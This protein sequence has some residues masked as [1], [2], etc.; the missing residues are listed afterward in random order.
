MRVL[1]VA[2][3][4]G[5]V[6]QAALDSG[7]AQVTDW[8]DASRGNVEK[9]QAPSPELVQALARHCPFATPPLISSSW[10]CASSRGRPG[11]A[12]RGVRSRVAQYGQGVDLEISRPSS[13]LGAAL[14]RIYLQKLLPFL[15]QSP[16]AIRI[17]HSS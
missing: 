10:L 1:D 13:Q 17:R 15:T 2:T 14:M 11:G 5:L 4:T 16:R 12:L 7:V 6:A 3:G 8:L 9:S